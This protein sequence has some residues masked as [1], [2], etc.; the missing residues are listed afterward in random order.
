MTAMAAKGPP[1]PS[2]AKAFWCFISYRHDDNSCPGRQWASWLHT[3]IETFEIPEELVGA[4]NLRGEL[5][6]SR[7]Y[8]V[9]RDEEELPAF[10]DL[11]A[12]IVNAL[13]QSINQLVIC[14]SSVRKSRFVDEEV[15]LFK[16]LGKS[17]RVYGFIIS[18]STDEGSADHCIPKP[19]SFEVD[20][21][22]KVL[23]RRSRPLL[24]DART[25]TGEEQ[26]I[27]ELI[28]T[29]ELLKSG[30]KPDEARKL[31]RLRALRLEE[32][33]LAVIAAILGIEPTRLVA[34]VENN[35]RRRRT[36][37]L[38]AIGTAAITV[39][40]GAVF[41]ASLI[42]EAQKAQRDA[43]VLSETTTSYVSKAENLIA[44]MTAQKKRTD[45][46]SIEKAHKDALSF[47]S[48][49][50]FVEAEALLGQN[51]SLGHP[52]SCYELALM[53]MRGQRSRSSQSEEV[54]LLERAAA[55]KY[56]AALSQL[57]Q[58]LQKSHD[59][60]DRLRGI[61]LLRAA[62]SAGRTDAELPLA[63][64]LKQT[65]PSESL[66]M[67]RRLS[68]TDTLAKHLLALELTPSSPAARSDGR[69]PEWLRLSLEVALAKP[70][71]KLEP[72]VKES[73]RKV[74]REFFESDGSPPY[75][76]GADALTAVINAAL[77]AFAAD[78]GFRQP[79]ASAI[80]S[81]R[82]MLLG[83]DMRLDL[84]RKAALRGSPEGMLLTAEILVAKTVDDT[85]G[86]SKEAFKWLALSAKEL[87]NETAELSGKLHSILSASCPPEHNHAE[88]ALKAY[89]KAAGS[90]GERSYFSD[91]ARLAK[92]LGKE[93]S[94]LPTITEAAGEGHAESMRILAEHLISEGRNPDEA[95]RLLKAAIKAG[96]GDAALSLGDWMGA[97]AKTPVQRDERIKTYLQGADLG[98]SLCAH[99]AAKAILE[100][101]LTGKEQ[102]Q[103]LLR[104]ACEG[105]HPEAM[106]DLGELLART[107]KGRG[108][109]LAEALAW[110]KVANLHGIRCESRIASLER[111]INSQDRQKAY[112]LY[113]QLM[114]KF[115]V[116]TLVPKTR[117]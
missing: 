114:E 86:T 48:I 22:A 37:N 115:P 1:K 44:D 106:N 13:K 67:L 16:S 71:G 57:G 46:L 109:D 15:A 30:V 101:G 104:Q 52:D 51:A 56:A 110:S 17:D 12:A 91:M 28:R 103:K 76:L 64:A 9:F 10:G 39:L 5:I 92:K 43:S 107:S 63:R 62:V 3:Q 68:T 7:I 54:E 33:K 55:A 70:V 74:C 112:S 80:R 78:P 20:A 59:A 85:S 58:V 117:K 89:L 25:E 19:L 38:V 113:R 23:P 35:R 34:A 108:E 75:D 84:C 42:L 45:T 94:V 79:L 102:A 90:G 40:S 69:P 60:K 98:S 82:L 97:H 41:G 26:W 100:A 111:S 36:F 116:K 18:G 11:S 50:K 77:D 87:P 73:L 61:G 32:A 95:S 27:D 8:P 29:E 99:R 72:A 53:G 66:E 14:S 4:R 31:S 65:S 24:I 47:L 21:H 2:G 105:G 81:Q 6:P 83:P 49:G 96:N 88:Q 93:S